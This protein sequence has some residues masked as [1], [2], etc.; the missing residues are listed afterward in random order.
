MRP[1]PPLKLPVGIL[2]YVIREFLNHGRIAGTHVVGEQMSN[3][4]AHRELPQR[5]PSGLTEPQR[6]SA[7]VALR[8]RQRLTSCSHSLC[9]TWQ[10]A[11]LC[12]L[13]CTRQSSRPRLYTTQQTL[14]ARRL[15]DSLRT[16]ALD[17][18]RQNTDPPPTIR[19]S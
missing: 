1:T 8:V 6:G 18:S 9:R 15:R 11:A 7:A 2:L 12:C 5:A 16:V 17:N 13:V 3:A 4:P 10:E 14:L 19:Q